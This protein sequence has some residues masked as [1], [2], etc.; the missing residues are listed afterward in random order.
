MTETSGK[1]TFTEVPSPFCGLGTDDLK[2]KVDGTSVKVMQNG[3]AVNTP[4]FEAPLGD[5][6]PRIDG[7]KTTLKAAIKKAAEIV[8]AAEL[9]VFGG[10][11]TDVE[12]M[13]AV[14]SLADRA[15]AVTDQVSF[16]G[17]LRNFLVLHDSGWINTTLAEVKNRADLLVVVGMDLESKL[18]RFFEQFVWNEEAMNLADTSDRKIVYLGEGPSGKASTSPRGNRAK[19]L[20]CSASDLPDVVAVLR[21]LVN[22]SVLLV[23]EVGGIPLTQ[24]KTLAEQLKKARYGVVTWSAGSLDFPQAELTIQMLCEMIKE[25]N[26]ETRCSGLPLAGGEGD[27]TS[28]QV[29]CWQT[30]YP[31]RVNFSA[32]FPDYDPYL[33]SVKAR[34]QDG[35]ADALLWVSSFNT[36]RTP[37]HTE[38][39][40]VVIGRAGMEFEKEPD[41]FIPVGVPGID[42]AGHAFRTDNV[43]AVRLSRLRDTALPATADVL[44]AI[45][46][47]MQG[48]A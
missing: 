8:S 23:D 36:E 22:D 10:L 9:P 37:P 13:R 38:L 16:G 25:L 11:A 41:V 19:T 20:K 15:G 32:G 14:L 28:Y 1:G 35:S 43:V 45:E 7:R 46:Q 24:L 21:A 3:C 44:K 29:S 27:L 4:G 18:P 26:R 12:G 47:T 31:S 30:G 6:R 39:P 5:T 17:G 40:T 48:A 33:N 42:H 2:I 34:L